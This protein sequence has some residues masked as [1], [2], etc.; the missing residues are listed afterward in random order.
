MK[1]SVLLTVGL[2]ASALIVAVGRSRALDS[3]APQLSRGASP[4]LSAART[5]DSE[6]ARAQGRNLRPARISEDPRP[7][8]DTQRASA[9]AASLT[10]EVRGHSDDTEKSDDESYAPFREMTERRARE[11]EAY[12]RDALGI[13]PELRQQLNEF[14]A[15]RI[16]A[17]LERTEGRLSGENESKELLYWDGRIRDLI[18]EERAE[19]LKAFR[20]KQSEESAREM[21]T[22][23]P[24]T[25]GVQN[26]VRETASTPSTFDE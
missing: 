11:R 23:I 9:G 3:Q 18:G 14:L 19:N 21:V 16:E 17:R 2:V 5:L 6:V 24:P 8:A 1:K 13:N 7:L 15:R 25:E 22:L 10:R 12:L 26:R 20:K 4:Q